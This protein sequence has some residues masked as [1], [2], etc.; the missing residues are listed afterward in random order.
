MNR[1]FQRGSKN[2][3]FR[4]EVKMKHKASMN[5]PE[6]IKKMLT[7]RERT[8]EKNFKLF[9]L[10]SPKMSEI[11][12]AKKW[13]LKGEKNP[14]FGRTGEKHPLFKKPRSKETKLKI[15]LTRKERYK[16][17]KIKKMIGADNPMFGKKLSESHKLALWGGWKKSPN[18]PERKILEAYPSLQYVGNGKY[19][20]LFKNGQRKNPDFLTQREN[21][22]IELFGNYWH[23]NENLDILKKKYKE[24]GIECLVIWENEVDNFMISDI[25]ERFINREDYEPFVSPY[26]EDYGICLNLLSKEIKEGLI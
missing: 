24:I 13:G 23:K 19:W 20:I 26:D 1:G 22:V 10:K 8:F 4:P 15:S 3:M 21:F 16:E 18:K 14:M 7:T 17:G 11:R 6:V 9:G 12:K 2:V 5:S 25:I